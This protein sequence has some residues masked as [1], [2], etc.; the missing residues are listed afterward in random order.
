MS[1]LNNLL[2]RVSLM[3][4]MSGPANAMANT[5]TNVTNRIQGGFNKIGYGSA[6]LWGI[7]SAVSSLTK[8]AIEFE[9][10]MASVN[11]VADFSSPKGFKDFGADLLKM[12]RIIPIAAS[13]LAKM[14]AAGGEQGIGTLDLP[15]FVDT[16]AKMSTAFDMSTSQAGESIG[17]LANIYSIP[18]NQIG[19]LGDAI[20]YLSNNT[21]SKASEIVDVLSRVG[22]IAGQMGI[23]VNQTAALSAA[24]LSLGQPAEIAGTSI[25]AMLLKLNT[26]R[27]QSS[28]FI[29]ALSGIGLSVN[30]LEKNIQAGPQQAINDFLGRISQLS[31][32]D[33]ALTLGNLFGAEYSDNLAILVGGLD[34]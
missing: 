18:I 5:V 15:G 4:R 31:K 1:A 22:G 11:K 26:A 34:M 14:A 9:S 3:D 28:D 19:A 21:N 30:Q 25:N 8:P 29:S 32:H 6:G 23:T 20:N 27:N 2:F 13:D 16:V 17:K 33:Q 10:A 12:S 7:S 24:M